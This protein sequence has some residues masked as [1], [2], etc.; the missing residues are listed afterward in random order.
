VRDE[1]GFI[2]PIASVN[3]TE[4]YYEVSGEGEPVVLIAGLGQG[5]NYF[6]YAIP[7]LATVGKVIALE[8]RGVGRSAHPPGPYSM[9][10]WG[11]DVIALLDH[12]DE[13]KAHIVG[14]SLG[15][16]I[17]MAMVDKH[18]DRIASL[19]LV[20]AFAHLDYALELNW[21]LRM[22]IVGR[23]GMDDTIQDHIT[24]W[25][26]GRRFLQTERGQKV[27]QDLRGGIAQ[28]DPELYL[29]F[30]QAILDF[31]RVTPETHG[32]P[33]Y[34]EVLRGVRL[35]TLLVVGADDILTPPALSEQIVAAMPAGVAELRVIEDCGHVTMVE[36]PE[37]NC[38]L[39]VD[40]IH[41]VIRDSATQASNPGGSVA[42]HA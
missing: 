9:E 34:L 25:T 16:C 23:S 29:Q 5:I 11:E 32:Q 31:G 39:I 21:R 33:T 12:L 37:E 15:G 30:L 17:A 7:K 2:V 41:G 42:K 20:A 27:A 18:P 26:L 22:R 13:Q 36:R 6:E 1:E 10:T 19:S 38:Q 40:F 4:L 28:N 8:L 3:G 14:A 24:L 35:P